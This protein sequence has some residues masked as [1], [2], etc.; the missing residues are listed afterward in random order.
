M[1]DAKPLIYERMANVLRSVGA[2]EKSQ[3]NVAQG[4]K[5]R[6]ID[7][8]YN[9]LHEHF[10]REQIFITT[11]VLHFDRRDIVLKS[12]STANGIM[13][14]IRFRFYAVDGSFVESTLVGEAMDS[15]DKAMNKALSIAMKYC[16]FQS[17]LI[18]TEEM[19]DPDRDAFERA[20][21]L[22]ARPM[23]INKATP[24]EPAQEAKTPVFE[25]SAAHRDMFAKIAAEHGLTMEGKTQ[26]MLRE[27]YR[28]LKGISLANVPA[29][30]ETLIK[31][32]DL[33]KEKK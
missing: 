26:D 15:G 17:F 30:F 16:L 29:R 23:V 18:P 24:P 10:S 6:G 28:K 12:G 8:V 11:D 14:T 1:S 20:K 2:I 7:Q 21:T 32:H 27:I 19:E 25:N 31:E 33:N 5:F 4:F 13:A 3:K 22:N 9:E